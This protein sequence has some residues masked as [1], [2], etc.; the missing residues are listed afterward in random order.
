[1]TGDVREGLKS[2]FSFQ[3]DSKDTS[4]EDPFHE[5]CLSISLLFEKMEMNCKLARRHKPVTADIDTTHLLHFQ[6]H[7]KI[8]MIT[9]T[10]GCK[11]GVVGFL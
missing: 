5:S 2:H 7:T 1:M 8:L 3:L 6:S 4:G 9:M 10:D 11:R